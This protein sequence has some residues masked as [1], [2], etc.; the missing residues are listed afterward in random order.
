MTEYGDWEPESTKTEK[1]PALEVGPI[2]GVLPFA[3]ARNPMFRSNTAHRVSMAIATPASKG[4]K[5][6][7]HFE[8]EGES[9]AATEV[10]LHP[11]LYDLE[12]QLP[13]IEYW[14][15]KKKQYSPHHFDMRVTFRDGFRR[16]IFVRNGS[17]L[18]RSDTQDEIEDIFRAVTPAFADDCIVV[19]TDDYSR[20]YRDNLRRMWW[21]YNLDDDEADR[22]VEEVARIAHYWLLRELISQCD[23]APA[24]A[25]QA[26]LRLIA[27][28]V[29]WA[30]WHAVI[31]YHSRVELQG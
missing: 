17:S 13:P 24:R 16:A 14:S 4:V 12:V 2:Y 9:A 27:R 26:A 29:L 6:V 25:C 8:S 3:G 30:D 23:L 11:D 7:Y 1:L 20:A 21:V 5:R 19:K 28:R 15:R 10:L 22:H 18:A 31:N